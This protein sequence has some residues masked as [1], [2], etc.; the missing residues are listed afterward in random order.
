MLVSRAPVLQRRTGLGRMSLPAVAPLVREAIPVP[1][2]ARTC[3]DCSSTCPRG[4]S[5][6]VTVTRGS[7][8][9]T[10]ELSKRL[11]SHV[12]ILEQA[13]L[14]RGNALACR[15]AAVT[16]DIVETLNGEEPTHGFEKT[17]TDG[18]LESSPPWTRVALET[19][20]RHS[21]KR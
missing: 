10:L 9:G 14:G 18:V 13:C 20:H 15:I 2:G 19:A 16:G 6:I 5:R 1:N 12:T 11:R 17:S 8:D 3:P 4:V 7:I 21:C